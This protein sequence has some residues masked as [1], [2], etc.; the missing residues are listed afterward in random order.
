MKKKS[1]GKVIITQ[2]GNKVYVTEK[3][4]NGKIVGGNAGFN[5]IRSGKKNIKALTKVL[6]DP[7]LVI[8][9]LG[10]KKKAKKK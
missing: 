7:K 4:R 9:K 10:T 6:K 5:D 3:A 2:K 1:T 8:K